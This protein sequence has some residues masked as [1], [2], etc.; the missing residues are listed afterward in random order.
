M[1][2][3]EGG[4]GRSEAPERLGPMSAGLMIVMVYLIVAPGLAALL[5]NAYEVGVNGQPFSGGA[6]IAFYQFGWVFVMF[7]AVPHALT[8]NW[9]PLWAYLA[10]I[11]LPLAML[12]MLEWKLGIYA[13]LALSACF[14]LAHWLNKRL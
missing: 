1:T 6:I 13:L 8:R 7:A 10:S 14:G 5:I 2:M 11:P 3:P 12:T 4:A 9:R